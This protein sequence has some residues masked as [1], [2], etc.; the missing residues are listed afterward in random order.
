MELIFATGNQ[1]KVKEF[2]QEL[3]GKYDVK[4]LAEIGFTDEL[5]EDQDTIEGNSLQKTQTLYNLIKKDCFGEDTGLEVAALDGEPGVYSARYAGDQKDS[6]ANMDLL[7]KNL[8]GKKDRSAQFK[9][10]IT[11]ILSD[12]VYQFEGILKGTIGHCKKGSGGFGYDP[13]FV[14]EDGRT[15]AELTLEE[16]STVS[17]RGK[18]VRKLIQFLQNDYIYKVE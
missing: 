18:A 14:L 2:Q 10:V 8:N 9:T 5:P 7:L 3:A 11:L 6:E 16:K 1:N 13:V 12:K 17:H 15:L 4:T